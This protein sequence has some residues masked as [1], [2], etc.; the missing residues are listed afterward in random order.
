MA[1]ADYTF[2][3]MFGEMLYKASGIMTK[4]YLRY[5]QRR[6]EIQRKRD[7]LRRQGANI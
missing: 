1:T 3:T 2:A 4:R 7:T 6:G 5:L